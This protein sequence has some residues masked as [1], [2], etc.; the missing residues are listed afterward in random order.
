MAG[1]SHH[2]IAL[3]HLFGIQVVQEVLVFIELIPCYLHKF[4]MDRFVGEFFPLHKGTGEATRVPVHHLHFEAF[5]SVL[6]VDDGIL[7]DHESLV[8]SVAMA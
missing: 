2:L 3:D 6:I 5:H 4:R 8:L 1:R 7:P